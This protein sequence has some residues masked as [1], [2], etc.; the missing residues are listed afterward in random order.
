MNL[1]IY[2]LVISFIITFLL[3]PVVIKIGKNFGILDQPNNRKIHENPTVRIGGLSI[4]LGLFSTSLIGLIFKNI[5]G[6]ENF[7]NGN[8]LILLFGGFLFFILGFLDDLINLSPILRLNLQF[9]I[10]IILWISGLKINGISFS[11]FKNQ[12][13]YF[14][15]PG[16][17][18]LIITCFFIVAVI[19]ALNWMDGLDGLAA[20]IS[21]IFF[22]SITFLDNNSIFL[23]TS[24]IGSL[25]A[26]LIFNLK[27]STIMMGDGGSYLLGFL[28]AAS[29]IISSY[30]IQDGSYI[31]YLN[32]ITPIFLLI[33]PLAD[34][35]R[36][37]CIRLLKGR[38]I[39]YPDNTHIH[40]QLLKI[41]LN[42]KNTLLLIFTIS[43]LFSSL[44]IRLSS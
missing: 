1:P 11:I 4:F 41:G 17:L 24:S 9:I 31:K 22:T 20:G 23:I 30:S 27:G 12:I 42:K 39:F 15:F 29:T 10:S 14:P 16:W 7:D 13:Y 3:I 6:F 35:L 44:G 38:S 32:I 5:S 34:M 19:N 25:F 26:F 21:I 36:V 43:I 37:I 8:Y 33:L 28:I 40:Y 2:N 18:G